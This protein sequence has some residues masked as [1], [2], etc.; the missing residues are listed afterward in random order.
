M[1][2]DMHQDGKGYS[3]HKCKQYWV[4]TAAPQSDC[5]GVEVYPWEPWPEGL[6]TKSQLNEKGYKPGVVAGVIKRDKSPNGWMNLYRIEDAKPKR[7]PSEKQLQALGKAKQ[8]KQENLTCKR[9]GTVVYSRRE[10]RGGLCEECQAVAMYKADRLEAGKIAY[11]IIREGNFVIWDSETTDL[12]GEFVEIAVI[13]Q[14]G[15]V[16]FNQRIAPQEFISPG[17]MAVHGIQDVDLVECPTFADI[18]C[19]LRQVLDGKRW[20]IY[21]AEFDEGVLYRET[22]YGEYRRFYRHY[23]IEAKKT[24]CIMRLFAQ[25]YGDW[26][27]YFNN[28]RWQKLEF[29]ASVFDVQV[30]APAHS[31]LGDVLRT[32]GVLHGM[33]KWYITEGI[34]G[35]G[36]EHATNDN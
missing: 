23:P 17:A 8:K 28:Y 26:H 24:N 4:K 22:E 1:N 12:D 25:W 16:L 20:L 15:S 5:P 33:A 29:A 7:K 27:D 11:E 30:D 13:D 34:Y 32:L 35:Y 6:F 3:C 2:H 31:A 9:C 10:I 19:D 36:Y 14:F 21:N 18:Y